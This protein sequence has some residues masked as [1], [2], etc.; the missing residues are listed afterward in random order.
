[1]EAAKRPILKLW[2]IKSHK[3]EKCTRF[4]IAERTPVWLRE[5][6]L[7]PQRTRNAE[8]TKKILRL[9]GML[10]I[11]A[12]PGLLFD[13]AVSVEH[14]RWLVVSPLAVFFNLRS[15]FC[16]LVV[17]PRDCFLSGVFLAFASFSVFIGRP[18]SQ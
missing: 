16:G 3:I 4:E 5:K 18:V 1:M 8:F 15:L 17:I 10:L 6:N 7:K 9:S 2:H 12:C 14:R 13:E 11:S